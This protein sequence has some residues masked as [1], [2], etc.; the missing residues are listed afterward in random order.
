M[1]YV[2]RSQTISYFNQGLLRQVS[3]AQDRAYL[4]IVGTNANGLY[5]EVLAPIKALTNGTLITLFSDN[6][7]NN[8]TVVS[9]GVVQVSK[10]STNQ[11]AINLTNYVV[12]TSNG[13]YNQIVASTNSLAQKVST[14][15]SRNLVLTSATNNLGVDVSATRFWGSG[16]NLT[17]VD[18]DLL[19]DP[20]SRNKSI[21][22]Y[23][24]LR[25]SVGTTWTLMGESVFNTGPT[26]TRSAA[27][28]GLPHAL[29]YAGTGATFMGV[30]T[31]AFSMYDTNDC[32]LS[33][34]FRL[35]GPISSNCVWVA[36]Q[37]SPGSSSVG[38][39]NNL[40]KGF[41]LRYCSTN[42]L[43]STF[44]L[45]TADGI[46]TNVVTSGVTPTAGTLYAVSVEKSGSNVVLYINGASTA[47]A[48]YLPSSGVQVGFQVQNS[49]LDVSASVTCSTTIWGVDE[50]FSWHNN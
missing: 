42:G 40:V 49:N 13:L 35:G 36:M 39:F 16:S 31:S 4:G 3:A 8:D 17:T 12:G 37:A 14:N 45:Y 19:L 27:T 6:W 46:S 34:V 2:C 41:G 33:T 30:A 15:D 28:N 26:P 11:L 43:D 5:I 9:N 10:D 18:R 38:R 1:V 50:A 48:N 44:K 20:V 23:A 32:V 22:F 24:H 29:D 21:W 25:P 47:T 7:T